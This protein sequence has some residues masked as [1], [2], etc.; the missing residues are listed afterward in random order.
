LQ[1][2]ARGINAA[3]TLGTDRCGVDPAM[4]AVAAAL[5]ELPD[6]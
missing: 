6:I 5:R 1:S 4:E 2:L 3:W